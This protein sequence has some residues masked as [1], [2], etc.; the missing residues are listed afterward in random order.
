MR[1]QGERQNFN[2]R[3][4]DYSSTTR[5][6]YDLEVDH[7]LTS[8]K[9][10]TTKTSTSLSETFGFLGLLLGLVINLGIIIVLSLTHLFGWILGLNK[11]TLTVDTLDGHIK[12]RR[13]TPS[14]VEEINRTKRPINIY[15]D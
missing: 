14:E 1:T 5:L 13:L 6:R 3:P 15:E 8:I 2:W 4:N 12:E 10:A 9:S 7:W 11:R